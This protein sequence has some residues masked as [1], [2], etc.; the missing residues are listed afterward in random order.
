MTQNTISKIVYCHECKYG[1]EPENIDK[2]YPIHC[3][4]YDVN[5]S[6][7]DFCSKG[8]TKRDKNTI[9]KSSYYVLDIA[10]YIVTKCVE[11]QKYITNLQLNE[12]MYIIQRDYLQKKG[13]TLF[14]DLFEAWRC[15]PILAEVYYFF[16]GA[17][18]APLTDTYKGENIIIVPEDKKRINKIIANTRE[19]DPWD[20]MVLVNNKDS[21]WKRT[22]DTFGNRSLISNEII[23]IYG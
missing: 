16:C 23:K 5:M 18:A 22:Y 3:L 17:G 9:Q 13:I 4:M 21:A 6:K 2:E 15:G 8:R 19:L 12:I 11:D 20:M 14:D 1:V 7:N 10:K